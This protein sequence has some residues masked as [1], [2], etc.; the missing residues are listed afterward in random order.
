[1]ASTEGTAEG[2]VKFYGLGDYGTYPQANR[3][4]EILAQFD[5]SSETFAVSDVLEFHNAQLFV[6]NEL[7]PMS[8]SDGERTACR[9]VL[10]QVRAT[11]AK[12]F[13]GLND[14]NAAT[15]LTDL[16][17]EYHDNLLDLLS[18][19]KVYDRCT[20]DKLLPILENAGIGVGEMLTSHSLVRSYDQTMRA[21]VLSNGHNAVHIVR[22]YL[23]SGS[24]RELYLPPSFTGDDA[25]SLLNDYLDSDDANPSFVELI[26]TARVNRAQGIDAKTKLK[27]QRKH[28][29][30]TR[31]FFDENSGIRTGCEVSI[32]A[33]QAQP[34]EVSSDGL[35]T[36]LSYSQNWLEENLDSPTVLNNFI[37]LFEFCDRRMLLNLP[38]YQAQ[39]GVFERI[40]KTTGRDAYGVGIA[41]R[42]MESAAFLQTAMYDRFL[43]VHGIDL[44]SVIEW[45]FAEYLPDNFGA[46]KFAFIPTSTAST[47]LEKC[48]HFF[49]E[50]ESV[51]R[52]FS[53]YAENGE[54][55]T[56]LLGVVSEQVRYSQIPS[57][58]SGKYV[59]T[60]KDRD[61]GII[62]HLL[63]SDQSR[64]AYISEALRAENAAQLLIDNRVAYNDFADHQRHEI[65]FLIERGILAD[66]GGRVE[67]TS[68]RQLLVL[69]DLVNFEAANYYHYSPTTRAE[70][71]NMITKGWLT[72]RE[73]L[74][75]GAEANYFNYYLNQVDFSNGPDLRNRYLHGSHV[76]ARD[77][78]EHHR[79][80][81]TALQ[82]LIALVIKIN[83][84][85]C[86]RGDVEVVER[87]K[88]DEGRSN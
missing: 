76:D 56:E 29:R 17:H 63:F 10:P 2:R 50:M 53:L 7:F 62:L 26:S 70:I 32:S 23:E 35:V 16:P 11:V 73:S 64:L 34:V 30:W 69:K 58:V 36:K 61:I 54:L 83:D 81:I 65:D 18:K 79:T 55:D 74:L 22:K 44:E 52:Q 40:I 27:A 39:L 8:Y 1:V 15:L 20:A 38:S 47:H 82:L 80:Y 12:F 71:E 72:R 88:P 3:A 4:A 75:T 84:D 51:V 49:A 87:K 48:R 85:F 9:A 77:E 42:F 5:P 66:T 31:D 86:L 19:Y 46:P 13:N 28:Q 59:Y 78:D 33:E 67:F 21:R 41:F 45:F 24:R 43:R 57:R 6:E 25:R 60:T 14:T 68:A 37:H